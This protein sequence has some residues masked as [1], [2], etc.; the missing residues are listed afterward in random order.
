MQEWET[1][2]WRRFA[3]CRPTS[4]RSFPPFSW[5]SFSLFADIR[6]PT[7]VMQCSS[8]LNHES[9][10]HCAEIAMNAQA[11]AAGFHQQMCAA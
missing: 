8:A 2:E 10:Q 3:W 6:W 9:R 5:L 4:A 1:G 11:G 7:I